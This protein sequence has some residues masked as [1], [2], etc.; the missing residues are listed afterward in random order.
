MSSGLETTLSLF[1]VFYCLVQPVTTAI[2][3]NPQGLVCFAGTAVLPSPY[4]L[5]LFQECLYACTYLAVG[6]GDV[7]TGEV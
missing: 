3:H 2:W 1:K 4:I 5:Q 6:A 7:V